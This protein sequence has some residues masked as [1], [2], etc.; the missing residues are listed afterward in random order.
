[1]FELEVPN[2]ESEDSDSDVEEILVYADVK[3][4][5]LQKSLE[6][7][8]DLPFRAIG[9]D[10]ENPYVQINKFIFKG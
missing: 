9:M 1:M 7:G 2:K 10:S 8:G 3:N 4:T 5:N 6:S